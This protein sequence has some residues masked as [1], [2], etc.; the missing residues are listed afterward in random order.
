ME[1]LIWNTYNLEQE[2]TPPPNMS[3]GNGTSKK[4][5]DFLGMQVQ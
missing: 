3:Y 1:Y 4:F 2:L 5:G